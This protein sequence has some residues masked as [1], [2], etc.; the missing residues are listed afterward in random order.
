M[1]KSDVAVRVIGSGAAILAGATGFAQAQD[2][3]G[4]YGGVAIGTDTGDFESYDNSFGIESG[5]T[6]S[7]FAGYNVV[8]GNLVYGGE[9]A[10]RGGFDADNGYVD[11]VGS[12]VDLKGRLGTMVGNTLVYGSLGYS[13]GSFDA[14]GESADLEGMNF[15]AGFEMPLSENGFFGGDITSRN[16]DANGE[17]DGDPAGQYM[18]NVKLTTVSVRLGFRF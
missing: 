12:L 15:G 3:G 4:F 5:S 16:L 18:D 1:K 14:E 9:V 17:I 6:S 13:L 8:S 10:W 2:V 11:S 7:V